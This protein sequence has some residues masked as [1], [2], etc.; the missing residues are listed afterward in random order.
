MWLAAVATA[1]VV[2]LI[3]VFLV[4]E[5]WLALRDV[6]LAHVV[7]DDSWFP[8]EGRFGMLPMLF[9]S[10]AVMVGATIVAS[11][12]AV[13]T[14]IFAD[15]YAPRSLRSMMQ[16]VLELL[17]GVPSVVFGLWGLVVLVPLIN[18]VEP[19]GASLLAG[20]VILSMMI[21]PT[22]AL[23]AHAALRGVSQEERR[24]AAATGLS[25][26]GTLRAVVLPQAWQG[27][28]TGILLGAARAVGETMA[29]LMVCGNV[30]TMPGSVFDPVR[31][32]TA[33]IALEMAYAT[34]QHRSLLF[35]SGLLLVLTV[36]VVLLLTA[37]INSGKRIPI[38]AAD[39]TWQ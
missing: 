7:G 34:G 25:R 5:S 18:R 31:T 23:F 6:G 26:W 17:A 9:A 10:A 33:N 16:I 4:S 35:L 30:A 11:P 21:V 13:G 15:S 19:P 28:V 3:G 8:L 22:I 37:V 12:I 27:I 38:R 29:V 20:V 39:A 32:L 1:G 2:V 14:A 24:H 36:A